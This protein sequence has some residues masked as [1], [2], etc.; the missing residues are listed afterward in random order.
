[1][2][3]DRLFVAGPGEIVSLPEGARGVEVYSL[4]GERLWSWRVG[5]GEARQ[6]ALPASIPRGVAQLRFLVR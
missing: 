2:L 1:M 4:R 6:A 5:D 3:R